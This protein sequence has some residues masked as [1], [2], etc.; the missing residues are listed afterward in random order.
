MRIRIRLL[1]AVLCFPLG[2]VAANE[3]DKTPVKR[4]VTIESAKS[5]EYIKRPESEPSSENEVTEPAGDTAE[6]DMDT[7][8]TDGEAAETDVNESEPVV[9]T[10]TPGAEVI[11]LRGNVS[12]VV[13]EGASVSKIQADEVI[14]DKERETLDA[15]GN[16]L[17]EHTT[18]KRGFQRF[19]GEALLFDIKKQEGVFLKGVITRDS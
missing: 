4:I 9:S 7:P 10:G 1:F 13:T 14:Y 5:T 8:E 12:I 16:V 15:Q 19:E 6:T 18:G 17:Y 2:F 3:P 11:R